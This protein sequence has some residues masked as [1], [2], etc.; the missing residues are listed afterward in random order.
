MNRRD[1]SRRD[2]R[3][4]SMFAGVRCLDLPLNESVASLSE[5]VQP[6]PHTIDPSPREIAVM[7]AVINRVINHASGT[8]VRR[9]RSRRSHSRAYSCRRASTRS[10]PCRDSRRRSRVDLG[11]IST[12]SRPHLGRIS[13]AGGAHAVRGDRVRRVTRPAHHRHRPE[14]QRD[15]RPRDRRHLANNSDAA[16][17]PEEA[18]PVGMRR[19]REGVHGAGRRD[20]PCETYRPG[21]P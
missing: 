7:N 10:S 16:A 12:A 21:A 14:P 6:P 15:G 18:R 1:L 5:C 20:R 11:Q 8:C 13:A 2:P 4:T 17:R 19:E 9:R 3:S